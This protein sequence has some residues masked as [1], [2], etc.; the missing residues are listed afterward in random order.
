[1]EYFIGIDIGTTN[2]KAV[3]ITAR[4]KIWGEER[5]AYGAIQ[6]L[7]GQFEQDPDIIC[8]AVL[9]I[10]RKLVT[11]LRPHQ[12]VSIGFS[13]A[14][15]G[16]MAVDENGKPLTRLIT[17]AD[18]R[19]TTFAESLASSTKGPVIYRITG[20][21]IHAMSPLCKLGWMRKALPRIWSK[22]K[23]FISIKEY[24]FFKLFGSYIIDQSIASATGLFD[25]RKKIWSAEALN[26]VEISPAQLSEPVSVFHSESVLDSK[27]ARSLKVPTGTPFVC[28]A[29]DGCLANLGTGA[30]DEFEAAVTIGTSGALRMASRHP[31]NDPGAILFNYILDDDWY[32]SGGPINNG[33]VVLKWLAEEVLG[34]K[35]DTI[36]EADQFVKKAFKAPAGSA[37]LVFL[38]YLLGERAPVW[39]GHARGAF[40]GLGMQHRSEHLMRAAMEG[41]SFALTQIL[42]ALETGEGRV[43][44]IYAS[45]GF[46]QSKPW[47]QMLADIF[48]KE[49]WHTSVADAS[50][51]GASMMAMRTSGIIKNWNNVDQLLPASKRY[52]P[53]KKEQQAYQKNWNVYKNLYGNLKDSLHQLQSQ[54]K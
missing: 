19:S 30:I 40:V 42:A 8:N 3:A 36:A 9:G 33:G 43:K 7:P 53:N 21:P 34:N 50:A 26:E 22:A 47:L 41:I 20:T 25:I 10:L 27:L 39:D 31:V 4:G 23:K 38:P 52:L 1:M 14:M 51:V 37:G 49:V 45:G 12:P 46:L 5:V 44:R 48:N 54:Q 24:L 32:V 15:H 2:A 29:S 6:S 13:S 18:T 28:G 35:L 11:K 16:L 17:W